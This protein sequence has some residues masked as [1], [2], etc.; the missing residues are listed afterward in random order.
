MTV[1]RDGV[2]AESCRRRGGFDM[3]D[4]L[5]VGYGCVVNWTVFYKQ[6]PIYIRVTFQK[7]LRNTKFT[8]LGLCAPK[9]RFSPTFFPEKL[10]V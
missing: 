10:G 8:E 6:L 7:I 4:R 2:A 1:K 9:P 3:A 5:T